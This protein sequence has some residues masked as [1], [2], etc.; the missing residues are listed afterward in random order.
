MPVTVAV[1]NPKGGSGKTTLCTNLA[2]AVQLDGNRVV[3]LDTDPQ[4]T[5]VRWASSSPDTYTVPVEHVPADGSRF[6]ANLTD[7]LDRTNAQIAFV[8]GS[9]AI[10]GT[11]GHVLR[12]AHAVLMPVQPTP[13]DV[14]GVEPV[15]DVVTEQGLPAAFVVV[16]AVVR[17]RLAREITDGLQATY[18]VPVF[19]HRMAQRV[20]Y[21]EAMFDGR[22]VLDLSGASKAQAEIDG[23][24][25]ELAALLSQS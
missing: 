14:W 17:T 13:A 5:A 19:E 10:K 9:A 21:A 23:I 22:T 25:T 2:R 8:D 3:I 6:K 18:G 11:T 1:L 24:T 16:R 15:V 7:R 20:A 4:G 12:H